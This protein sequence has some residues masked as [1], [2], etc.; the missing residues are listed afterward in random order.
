M[1]AQAKV[2]LD[3]SLVGNAKATLKETARAARELATIATEAIEKQ[4]TFEERLNSRLKSRLS[5]LQQLSQIK[6]AAVTALPEVARAG[7]A[8]AAEA[9]AQLSD[10]E[11]YQQKL[12]GTLQRL[13]EKERL[14]ADVAK[15][16]GTKEPTQEEQYQA[17]LASSL[18]R[19]QEKQRL[20]SD[21]DKASGVKEPT[22][23]EKYQAKLAATLGRLQE[24]ARIKA[25]IDRAAGAKEL[26]AEEKYQ[27]KLEQTRQ[28]LLERQRLKVDLEQHGPSRPAPTADELY[29]QKLQKR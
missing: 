23:E 2:A 4:S 25:D 14:K 21:I 20:K 9:K 1:S 7:G 16:L 13:K 17:K 6:P 3:V 10:E 5:L 28:R 15:A 19:L 29:Q 27:Q 18:Q 12:A 11:K 22:D 8:R 26:S 24:K